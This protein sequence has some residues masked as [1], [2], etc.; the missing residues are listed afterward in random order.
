[1][2]LREK[3]FKALHERNAIQRKLARQFLFNA[4]QRL[5]FHLTGDHFYEIVPNTRTVARKYFEG[6]RPLPGIDW[7]LNECEQRALRLV[8]DYG[9]EYP[10][11]CARFGFRERNAYFRGMDALMLYLVLRDT[12][13][14]KIV[15]VGQGFST[16]IALAA[17]E[18]NAQETGTRPLFVSVDPYARF[19]AEDVPSAISLEL[20]RRDLT[21]VEI[22]PLVEACEFFFVDSSH[23]YKFGSDVALELTTIYPQ[24]PAKTLLHLHD[25]FSPFDYPRDWIVDDKR[26]WNEQYAF[27]CFLMFNSVFETYL[28][29][30]LLARS[31]K[32][33]TDAIR[34]LPV[35][36]EFEFSG[37]SF[38][39]SRH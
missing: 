25:I 16:R 36:D 26:F 39:I 23:V 3:L 18:R 20:I 10:Q 4:F 1:M 28:P 34:R 35:D 14:S 24:L 37:S 5:G 9:P 12:K 11:A 21:E 7:R 27:E 31:S 30:H 6:A 19:V 33:V 32:N 8:N 22:G 17:L 15:E 2:G 29:V 38:Y 13:P